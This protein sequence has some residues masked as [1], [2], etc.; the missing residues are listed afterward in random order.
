M[1]L[2]V[3]HLTNA[4]LSGLD[5]TDHVYD[6]EDLTDDDDD[7]E[8]DEYGRQSNRYCGFA[9]SFLDKGVSKQLPV[10]THY[11]TVKFV[12][13]EVSAIYMQF[14]SWQKYLSWQSKPVHKHTQSFKYD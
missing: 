4:Y 5:Y 10:L 3:F 9:Q 14:L 2:K 8:D 11:K 13:P 1:L 7:D 12:T 6:Y